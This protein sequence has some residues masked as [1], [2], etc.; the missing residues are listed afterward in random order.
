ML[1][2]TL[3]QG[4]MFLMM[5]YFGIVCGILLTIKNMICNL[6]KQNKIV[7]IASDILFCLVSTFVF[8][9]AKIAFCYGQFRIFELIAF[10][11]GITIQQISLN[12]I[13]EKIFHLLYTLLER[14]FCKL[15]NSKFGKK[16]FKWDYGKTKIDFYLNKSIYCSYICNIF[17]CFA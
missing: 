7:I 5:L 10:V 17:C 12:K 2:E 15:K 13:V 11:L 16:I 3:L 1:Y 14:L 9:F 4:K 8:V 6:L